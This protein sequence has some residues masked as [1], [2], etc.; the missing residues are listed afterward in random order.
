M[1]PPAMGSQ[2]G[3]R[4]QFGRACARIAENLA[5]T[6]HNRLARHRMIARH[7][8]VECGSM[9]RGQGGASGFVGHELF[10]DAV[11]ERMERH[12]HQL[13]AFGQ[14]GI[15]GLERALQLAQ[16]VI[17]G[18]AQ[19]LECAGRGVDVIGLVIDLRADG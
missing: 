15:G 2:F 9:A 8:P 1:D 6:R 13:A 16:F 14:H 19:R 17:D 11:F 10:D 4:P 5:V 18:D 7:L 12:N 3:N